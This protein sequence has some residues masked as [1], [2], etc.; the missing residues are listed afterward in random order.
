MNKKAVA[1]STVIAIILLCGTHV[2]NGEP[3]AIAATA[4]TRYLRELY[5]E[6]IASNVAQVL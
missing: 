3:S 6:A 5:F 4:L 2:N 1:K